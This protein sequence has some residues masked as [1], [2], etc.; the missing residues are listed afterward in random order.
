MD[1]SIGQVKVMGEENLRFAED[2]S[3]KAI[4]HVR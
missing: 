1:Q 2:V 4:G 3:T